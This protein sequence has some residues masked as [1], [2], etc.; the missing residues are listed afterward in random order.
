MPSLPTGIPRSLRAIRVLWSGLLPSLLPA[1]GFE[2]S[3]R[4]T[5]HGLSEWRYG[6]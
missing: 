2:M 4:R 5:I 1:R 6:P 3:E